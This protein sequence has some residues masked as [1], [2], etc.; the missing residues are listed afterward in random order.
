LI[1]EVLAQ[2]VTY[3]DCDDNHDSAHDTARDAERLLI[4]LIGLDN[5]LNSRHGGA[6]RVPNDTR[7]GGVFIIVCV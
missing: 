1:T 2:Y 5:L 6:G 3:V 7:I 4:R